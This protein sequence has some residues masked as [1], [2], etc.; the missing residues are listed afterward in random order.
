MRPERRVRRDA[1]FQSRLD[2]GWNSLDPISDT[3]E[4]RVSIRRLDELDPAVPD[5]RL[6]KIDVEGGEAKVLRGMPA[7]FAR[8][9]AFDYICPRL[10]SPEPILAGDSLICWAA[11]AR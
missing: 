8:D 2:T 7:V 4:V 9:A 6:V 11:A 10:I 5:I 3:E 1:F